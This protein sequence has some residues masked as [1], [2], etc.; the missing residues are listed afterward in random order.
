MLLVR[1]AKETAQTHLFLGLQEV[2]PL[3]LIVKCDFEL[4]PHLTRAL[5]ASVL[6]VIVAL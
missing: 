2:K 5:L 4:N 1:E 6:G 3:L